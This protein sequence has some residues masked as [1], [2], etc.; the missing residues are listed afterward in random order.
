[1]SNRDRV[2]AGPTVVPVSDLRRHAARFIDLVTTAN[3]HVF[4]AQRGYV[5]AVLVSRAEYEALI[6]CREE[7]ERDIAARG[8]S[9]GSPSPRDERDWLALSVVQTGR[10]NEDLL[11]RPFW[12]EY[13]WCDYESA[14]TLAQQGVATELVKSDDGWLPDDEG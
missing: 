1:M 14:R 8:S 2:Q 11:S 4:V 6:R 10:S 5:T 13:G 3:A 7:R 9:L 12:T